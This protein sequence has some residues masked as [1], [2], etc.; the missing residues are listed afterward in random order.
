MHKSIILEISER[1]RT[2]TQSFSFTEY[3]NMSVVSIKNRRN[4]LRK[5]IKLLGNE[6]IVIKH[7]QTE[8]RIFNGRLKIYNQAS[9]EIVLSVINKICRQVAA[10]YT[11]QIPFKEIVIIGNPTVSFSFIIPLMG[12][13]RLFTVV[14]DEMPGKKADELY[15][16]YGCI[17]RHMSEL[18]KLADNDR[19][20]IRADEQTIPDVFSIPII[21]VT[22][23][24]LYGNNV[25]DAHKISVTDDN[26]ENIAEEWGGVSGLML[27]NLFGLSPSESARADI[28]KKADEIFLLDIEKF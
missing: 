26:I 8:H 25:I 6:D 27:Y 11:M 12:I 18:K 2:L 4:A 19:I 9:Y 15:F 20:I 21:D 1:G 14:S 28:N 7:Q 10:R 16:E 13:S 24:P 3:E 17:I 22:D 5:V 23:A